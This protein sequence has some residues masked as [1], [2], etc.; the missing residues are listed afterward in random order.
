MPAR[1]SAPYGCAAASVVERGAVSA[2]QLATLREAGVTDGEA[3][4]VVTNVVLNIFTNY[5][6]LLADTDIDFPVVRA[7]SR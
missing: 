4:E 3:L 5:V 6:N 2:A 7:A 1:S